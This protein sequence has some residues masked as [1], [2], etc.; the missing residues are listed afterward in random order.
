MW[1]GAAGRRESEGRLTI[2]SEDVAIA[3]PYVF[4]ERSEKSQGGGGSAPV[5][6][7]YIYTMTNKSKTLYS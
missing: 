2:G 3:V 5:A 4:L 1:G 6:E 7:Y